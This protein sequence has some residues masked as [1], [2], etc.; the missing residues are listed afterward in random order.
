MQNVVQLLWRA[1]LW[2]LFLKSVTVF[3]SYGCKKINC[4]K[5]QQN[6]HPKF[7]MKCFHFSYDFLLLLSII[8]N[9]KLQILK[10]EIQKSSD[11]KQSAPLT[12]LDHQFLFLIH[13]YSAAEIWHFIRKRN[14]NDK[15]H[16]FYDEKEQE[17][18]KKVF[19]ILNSLHW[20]VI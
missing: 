6:L 8:E 5:I 20:Q 12:I 16:K 3:C 19:L 18:A 10:I 7:S 2:R 15:K 13:W 11:T 1:V 14:E 9:Y 17:E 4:C